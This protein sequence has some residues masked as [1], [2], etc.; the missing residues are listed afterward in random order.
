MLF[1]QKAV[2]SITVPVWVLLGFAAWTM[3]NL[4][5]T[6]I[7]EFRADKIEGEDWYRRAMRAH[8]NC[9]RI[10]RSTGRWWLP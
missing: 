3:L 6:E 5:A 4:L 2:A 7:K 10:F 1:T 9:V 8:A